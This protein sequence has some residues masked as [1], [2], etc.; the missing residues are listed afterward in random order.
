MPLENDVVRDFIPQYKSLD[1]DLERY[2]DVLV[3]M[4]E[5]GEIERTQGQSL[6]TMGL[7]EA[8][9][10]FIEECYFERGLYDEIE[11]YYTASGEIAFDWPDDAARHVMARFTELGQ[12]TRTKRLWRHHIALLKG[13]Y[14]RYL[15]ALGQDKDNHGLRT[16]IDGYKPLLLEIMAAYGEVLETV[17]AGEGERARLRGDMTDV[18]QETRRPPAGKPDGRK[19]DEPLF[20][21]I[22]ETGLDDG[23]PFGE[24]IEAITERLTQFKPAAIKAFHRFVQTRMA[25]SYRSDIW[26]LAYLLQDGCSDDAFLAFRAWLILQGRDVFIATMQQPDGFDVTRMQGLADGAESL[27]E[28]AAIAYDARSG[29]PMPLPAHKRLTLKG[30][31]LDEADFT[32]ALPK[33]AKKLS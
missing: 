19:M 9:R 11:R 29:A 7:P 23:A 5:R 30:P 25:E 8:G 3:E 1:K 24:R 15:A 2:E 6:A 33:V 32:A 4:L 18:K 31:A 14:W 13:T 17:S 26:A 10:R 21:E 22:I 20:W 27:M 12:S 16:R 28:V